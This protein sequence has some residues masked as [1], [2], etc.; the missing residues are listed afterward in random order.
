MPPEFKWT[1]KG[2]TLV[3][4]L[5]KVTCEM[6]LVPPPLVAEMLSE[7]PDAGKDSPQPLA[8]F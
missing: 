3:K 2:A 5:V 7:M 4:V 6:P 8:T 1:S